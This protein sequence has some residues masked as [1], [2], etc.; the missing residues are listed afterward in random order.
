MSTEKR[1]SARMKREVAVILHNIRSI[2]NVGSAFRTSDAAGISCLYLTGYTPTP[3]DRFNRPRKDLAKVALGAE[4]N[5]TWEHAEDI[6][7]LISKLKKQNYTIIAIEQNKNS[8]DYKSVLLPER[9]ALIFGAEV[10][11]LSQEVL[12]AC[13]IIAE[14][15]MAGKKESLNVSVALGIA[16]FRMLNL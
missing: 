16:L 2:H 4:K 3:L 15:P 6:F 7:D 8:V 9:S 13:D 12:K 5:L 1:Y 10:E 14:I 11:G